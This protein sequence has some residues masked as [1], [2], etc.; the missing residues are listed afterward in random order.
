MENAS[1]ALMMAGAV[2][3]T[4]MVFGMFIYFISEFSGYPAQQEELLRIEQVAKFNQ[5]YESY[6]K[7][8]MYGTDVV[9]IMN[10]VISNNKKYADPITGRYEINADNHYINVEIKMSSEIKPFAEAY[11]EVEDTD[12]MDANDPIVNMTLI[13][14]CTIRGEIIDGNSTESF[15]KEL[16]PIA[17][18]KENITLMQ[19]HGKFMVSNQ[20]VE[21]FFSSEEVVKIKLTSPTEYNNEK[22]ANKKYDKF[23]Y[24]LVYSGFT[25]FK[26]KLFKCT[27]IEYNKETGMVNKISFA[28]I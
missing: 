7:D 13:E 18:S 26:R 17:N 14:N 8:K 11:N 4:I 27:G 25:D 9:T 24:T 6:Y 28:E 20:T 23:N 19:E 3:I 2:L 21:E 12:N 22:V 10:K 5:E 1:K 16:K 15:Q